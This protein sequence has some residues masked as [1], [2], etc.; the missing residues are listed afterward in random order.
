MSVTGYI[1]FNIRCKR[2]NKIIV[3]TYKLTTNFSNLSTEASILSILMK[4]PSG[5]SSHTVQRGSNGGITDSNSAE[6]MDGRLVCL[7]HVV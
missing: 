6:R 4:P 3:L 2:K 1:L 7:L 5:P